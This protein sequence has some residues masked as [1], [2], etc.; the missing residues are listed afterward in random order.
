MENAPGR[1]SVKDVD[2]SIE[3]GFTPWESFYSDKFNVGNVG[4]SATK[5]IKITSGFS[6]PVFGKL[7]ANPY[8]EQVYFVFGITL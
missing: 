8:E 2:L 3:A 4:L 5:E 7:I 1:A 6:L